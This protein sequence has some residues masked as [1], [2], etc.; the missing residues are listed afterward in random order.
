MVEALLSTGVDNHV[1]KVEDHYLLGSAFESAQDLAV[2]DIGARWL[3]V[4]QLDHLGECVCPLGA[5]RTV[6]S[7]TSV[8]RPGQCPRP[9]K[10][11]WVLVD[12]RDETVRDGYPRG[13]ADASEDLSV[14]LGQDPQDVR[15]RLAVVP[16]SSVMVADLDSPTAVRLWARLVAGGHVGRDQVMGVAQTPRGYHVWLACRAGGWSARMSKRWLRRWLAGV[17]GAGALDLRTGE[18]SYLVWPGDGGV[19]AADS[20]HWLTR[21]EYRA[22]LAGGSRAAVDAARKWAVA[23]DPAWGPPWAA[24]PETVTRQ[25]PVLGP[26][27]SDQIELPGLGVGGGSEVAGDMGREQM[28]GRAWRSLRQALGRLREMGEDSG[29]NNRL[30]AVAYY[31]ASVVIVLGADRAVVEHELEDA[32]RACR[33]P[34]ARATIRSGL[35]SGLAQLAAQGL[36]L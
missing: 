29:R 25:V 33:C 4:W 12:G 10:H 30:N 11:P 5:A 9:G 31:R 24:D 18:R 23:G 3:R 35:D 1:D 8:A 17:P 21:N 26:G 2:L 16:G 19:W 32:A 20:R 6:Q 13:V 34:G 28:L 22:V 14:V 36:S 15:S 27:L 7:W